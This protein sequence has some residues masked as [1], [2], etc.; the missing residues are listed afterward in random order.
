MKYEKIPAE[1]FTANRARLAKLLPKNSLV[2]LNAND[3]PPTN[4]DGVMCMTPNSDL[5][6][7]SGIEQEQTILVLYPDAD[8]EEHREMLF[9]REPTPELELC[10]GHKLTSE[11]ARAIS[12]VKRIRWLSEFPRLFHRL[13]CESSHVFL[14]SNEHK[15]AV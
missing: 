1:L 15:R 5:F 7:L 6:Y 9:V 13:M 8:E 12:G 14:N 2:V 4:A 10:D 11:E 3:V